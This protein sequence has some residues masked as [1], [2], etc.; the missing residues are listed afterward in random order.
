MTGSLATDDQIRDLLTDSRL[1]FVVGL[2]GF[3]ETGLHREAKI[4]AGAEVE[5]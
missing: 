5:V 3:F 4:V 2:G 1:W